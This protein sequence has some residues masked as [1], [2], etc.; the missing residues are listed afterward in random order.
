M[1]WFSDFKDI[2]QNLSKDPHILA[3]QKE[4]D[5]QEMKT[6]AAARSSASARNDQPS[7]PHQQ[8]VK[9]GFSAGNPGAQ[10]RQVV[11]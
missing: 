11:K 1:V 3:V 6:E 2:F 7:P 4:A 8:P 5:V 10:L 9:D